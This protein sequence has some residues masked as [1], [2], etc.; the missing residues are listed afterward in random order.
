MVEK[1][2][3]DTLIRLG[4]MPAFYRQTDRQTER[5]KL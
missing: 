4:T 3:E 2:F 1:K 5:Q